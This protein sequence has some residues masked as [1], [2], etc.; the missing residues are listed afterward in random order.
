MAIS[1]FKPHS[2]DS[3]RNFTTDAFS[4]ILAAVS[5]P[6]QNITLFFHDITNLAQIQADRE[7]LERENERLREWYQT[8]LFLQSENQ[9][10]R[11]LLNLKVDKKYDHVSARVLSDAGNTYLKSLVVIAG[12]SDGVQKESAVLSAQGL[13]GRIIDVGDKTSRILLITDIN[14]RVPVVVED[15]GQH[16]IMAGSNDDL[17][18]LIHLPQ[19][20]EI[21]EGAHVITSGY[22]GVYPRGLP[23]GRVVMTKQG[24]L[25]VMLFADFNALQIVRILQ[26]KN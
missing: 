21:S 10:L 18:R 16:A 23:V 26:E 11:A 20:S 6:M 25:G 7:R 5:Y 1:G 19:D 13:I 8:A 17:P 22:G 9:S 14:S 4:P 12:A 2:F 24:K 3:L 15:T